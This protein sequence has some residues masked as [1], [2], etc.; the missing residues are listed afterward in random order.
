M[1][2]EAMEIDE[3]AGE[4]ACGSREVYL[5][6]L[7]TFA[8]TNDFCRDE[9]QRYYQSGDISNYAVKVHA[10]KSSAKLAGATSLAEEALYMEKCAKDN[11]RE[12]IAKW[13]DVLMLH[14]DET[15]QIIRDKYCTQADRTIR[16]FDIDEFKDALEK[17]CASNEGFD[18]DTVE[19]SMDDILGMQI[20]E[21]LADGISELKTAVFMYDRGAIKKLIAE[22]MGGM[23]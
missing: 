10:L 4:K 16:E 19:K 9:I 3:E 17:M 12:E 6:V 13:H 22:I 7:D 1:W 8:Q 20:P 14:M 5:E 15:A 2:N 21:E 11:N 18:F 23:E